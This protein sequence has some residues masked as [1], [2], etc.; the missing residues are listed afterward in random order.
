VSPIKPI[1]QTN[2]GDTMQDLLPE[3][4]KTDPCRDLKTKL[5]EL[6]AA[7]ERLNQERE[8]LIDDIQDI[9]SAWEEAHDDRYQLPF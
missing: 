1:Q 3:P 2:R 8:N 6:E 4:I 9:Y 5:A 7:I